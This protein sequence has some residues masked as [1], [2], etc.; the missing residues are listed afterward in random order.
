MVQ[1]WLDAVVDDLVVSPGILLPEQGVERGHFPE[2]GRTPIT[3][4]ASLQVCS[5]ARSRGR[6]SATAPKVYPPDGPSTRAYPAPPAAARRARRPHSPP[7]G[8]SVALT[9]LPRGDARV[10][11]VGLGRRR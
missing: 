2:A 4:W 1:D 3:W 7:S 11:R 5:G 6:R 9:H 10:S 8:R